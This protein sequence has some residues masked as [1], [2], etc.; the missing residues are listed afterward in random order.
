MDR[1]I[2]PY[3]EPQ[4]TGVPAPS[5]GV[6]LPQAAAPAVI[7]PVPTPSKAPADY[8]RAL[9]RRF[10]LTVLVAGVLGTVGSILVLRQEPVYR[11][12]AQIEIRPPRFDEVLSN[13]LAEDSVKLNSVTDEQYE[14]NWLAQLRNKALVD[15]VLFKPQVGPSSK[16]LEVEARELI[17]NLRTH[18]LPRT[19]R[20]DVHLEGGNPDR[21]ATILNLWLQEFRQQ[22][23]DEIGDQI[24]NSR[25]RAES[26]RDDLERQLTEINDQIVSSLRDQPRLTP[27][28]ENLLQRQFESLEEMKSRTLASL[29]DLD[30]QR[31]MMKL[32]PN[33]RSDQGSARDRR[34]LYELQQREW[35]L[36]QVVMEVKRRTKKWRSDPAY[37]HY[38]AQLKDIQTQIQE[39]Q[40]AL[41][42]SET[43]GDPAERLITQLRDNL[44][45]DLTRVEEQRQ[46]VLSELHVMAPEHY[47][48]LMLLSE[49]EQTA[50]AKAEMETKLASFNTLTETR[51]DPIEIKQ[52]ASVPTKPIGPN[53]KLHLVLVALLA[54]GAGF[55]IVVLLEHIDHSVRAPEHLSTG[56][57][58]PLLGVIPRMKR[59]ARLHRGGHLFTPNA[60]GSPEADAF[61]N[62][63]ASLLGARDPETHPAVTI[64]ITSAKAGEG[65]STTALNLAATCARS[66]E[67]T[68][69]L[70]IDLRRPSLR[71]VF[72]DGEHDLG[73]VDVLR[74]ELPWQRTVLRTDVPNLDFLPTGDPAGIPIEILGALELK[75]LLAAVSRHYDRVILDGPAILGL[76]DCRVLGRVVDGSI[77][78]VR[79]GAH[80]LRPLARAKAML[81][82]SKSHIIGAVFNG[83]NEDLENWS[84]AAVYHGDDRRDARPALSSEPA[85]DD[86]NEALAGVQPIQG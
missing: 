61:R 13:L 1:M 16:P 7:S 32:F 69:L 43:A 52:A 45:N 70:D 48:F 29:K 51:N 67:R 26:N 21:I 10:W 71:P 53:Y 6:A 75:Q 65:K 81:E 39:L 5:A 44:R 24:R 84:C 8:V 73:V 2:L 57:T 58:L 14:A 34:L 17:E 60:P 59:A 12:S 33:M 35:Q 25:Q 72:D 66:G 18:Q 3:D 22:A 11:A 78:V 76:A 30:R 74:G 62:L 79:A 4:R 27:T 83:L 41:G 82:Q 19:T 40:A 31:M 77:F 37:K 47:E 63:R 49:R 23:A 55:G 64:L 50:E 85:A 28:G 86:D 36:E 42:Q 54:L 46:D 15:R 56:L 68:L 80:D 20:F 38:A 9:R